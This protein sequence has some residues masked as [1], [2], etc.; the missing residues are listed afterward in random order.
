MCLQD[1]FSTGAVAHD[2]GTVHLVH[3]TGLVF[4]RQFGIVAGNEVVQA[5]AKLRRRIGEAIKVFVGEGGIWHKGGTVLQPGQEITC[6]CIND[7][8]GTNGRLRI[9]CAGPAFCSWRSSSVQV[10]DT[11]IAD[12]IGAVVEVVIRGG[13]VQR[14]A[15]GFIQRQ[16]N[17]YIC[18]ERE[19]ILI[20]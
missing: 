12:V 14:S 8:A 6:L 10:Q 20:A 9:A 1:K 3:R 17:I 19:L 18:S 5:Q 2:V 4:Q 7:G 16:V 11:D 13:K 15:F